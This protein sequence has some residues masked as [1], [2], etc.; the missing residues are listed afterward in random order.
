MKSRSLLIILDGPPPSFL[1][2]AAV[3][4]L[5]PLLYNIDFAEMIV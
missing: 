4:A 3:L 2:A 1:A 5:L